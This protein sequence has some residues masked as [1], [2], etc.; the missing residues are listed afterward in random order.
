MIDQLRRLVLSLSVR[1]RIVIVVAVLLVGGGLWALQHWNKERDFKP[2]Y[3]G[4]SSEDAGAIVAKLKETASEYRILENGSGILVPSSKVAEL[5]LQMASAGLPKSGRIG[6]ELFDKMNFGQTDFAEQV[7]YRRALE[8][9]LERSIMSMSE[10]EQ[11]RVHLSFAKDSLYTE[12]KQDAKASVLVKLKA[13]AKLTVPNVDA[14]RHLVSSAVEGLQPEMVSV[15]DSKGQVMRGTG[16]ADSGAEASDH[17]LEFR[18]KIEQSLLEKVNMTLEPLLGAQRFH[19]GVTVD[20]DFS[21]GD[22]SEETF[23][24]NKSVM[25][26]SQ[27]SEDTGTTTSSGGVPGTQSN[28]PRPPARPLTGAGLLSRRTESVSFQ[29]S[30]MVKHMKLPEGN[31]KRVSVSVLL[32]QRFHWDV[33]KGKPKRVL[34]PPTAEQLKVVKDL[35]SG[36]VG[37]DTSRGDQLVVQTLPFDVTLASEPPADLIPAPPASTGAPLSKPVVEPL[38]KQPKIQMIAGAAAGVTLLLVGMVFMLF[39]KKKK[40]IS[41]ETKVAIEGQTA[42]GGAAKQ[43]PSTETL[44]PE[45]R[46]ADAAALAEQQAQE[47]LGAIKLPDSTTKKGEVLKRHIREEIKKS[48]EAISHVLRTWLSSSE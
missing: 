40:T 39:R 14:L 2:L 23:D 37:L 48:P 31:L 10:I 1:Q 18:K 30:R 27:R 26:N 13:G 15:V 34:D 7:N 35:V 3:T 17:M 44:D 21:S 43:I 46:D 11:A 41:T 12:S 6:Y 16:K 28:L 9:E 45:K 29:T 24:P 5:R 42:P 22:Q 38:W 47:V 19:A 20:C 36:V 25:V 8:G 32:D 4:L 33:E